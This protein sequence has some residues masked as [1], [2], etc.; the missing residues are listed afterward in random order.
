MA[1]TGYPCCHRLADYHRT[2][3]LTRWKNEHGSSPELFQQTSE[4]HASDELHSPPEVEIAYPSAHFPRVRF[5]EPPSG[6]AEVC[7]RN[8][9]H[10]SR[11]RFDEIEQ[12]LAWDEGA[13]VQHPPLLRR[14]VDFEEPV[15]NGVSDIPDAAVNLASEVGFRITSRLYEVLG[16]ANAVALDCHA[17]NPGPQ[18]LRARLVLRLLACDPVYRDENRDSLRC[19]QTHVSGSERVLGMNDIRTA[20]SYDLRECLSLACVPGRE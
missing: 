17:E 9:R 11:H 19:S 13:C 10:D 3:L 12:P 6:D 4:I 16:V 7:S 5:V 8:M 1:T 2:R 20:S 15:G 18:P 14:R